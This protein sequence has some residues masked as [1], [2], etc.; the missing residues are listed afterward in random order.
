MPRSARIALPL[1]IATLSGGCVF[2]ETRS[3]ALN[4]AQYLGA[5]AL[6]SKNQRDRQTQENFEQDLAKTR[7]NAARGR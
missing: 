1:L 7:E 6:D 4:A 5:A 3:P 2:V